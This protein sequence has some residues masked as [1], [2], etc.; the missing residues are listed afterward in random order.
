MY[1]YLNKFVFKCIIKNIYSYKE[2]LK[3][4]IMN[5]INKSNYKLIG[6]IIKLNRINVGV[7]QVVLCRDICVPSYL[8]RIESG[9]ILPSDDIVKDLFLALNIKYNDNTKFIED[10]LKLFN[11]FYNYLSIGHFMQAEEI[12]KKIQ[13]VKDEYL[14][15]PLIVEY[16]LLCFTKFSSTEHRDE[17]EKL[18]KMLQSIFDLMDRDK[19]F[20]FCYNIAMDTLLYNN[21]PDE[22]LKYCQ[23]ANKYGE[24]GLLYVWYSFAYS[25]KKNVIKAYIYAQKALETFV[26]DADVVNIR[27][28]YE[29]I[30][31]IY[32]LQNHYDDAIQYYEKSKVI[33]NKVEFDYVSKFL[34]SKIAFCLYKQENFLKAYDII[35][36]N[37][38]SMMNT[39]YVPNIVTKC[40][41]LIKQNDLFKL[42]QEFEK[43]SG[44]N[45]LKIYSKEL[46]ENLKIFFEIRLNNEHFY[47]DKAYEKAILNILEH[48]TKIVELHKEFTLFLND[49]Y[50]HNRKYKEIVKL[51][52]NI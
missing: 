35:N 3:G 46:A 23:E 34:D 6:T 25:L 36:D 22:G 32:C 24:S 8:S 9:E 44:L 19:K 1:M 30:G 29:I 38:V 18:K 31:D 48:S 40:L 27:Y 37:Y 39:T 51:N 33:S 14:S 43:L 17:V 13:S 42:R 50:I 28:A 12:F 21:N 47:K 11:N 7:S 16:Y 10:N 15:S 5:M 49:Y 26:R 52:L 41:I 20:K 2:E 4:D 45:S